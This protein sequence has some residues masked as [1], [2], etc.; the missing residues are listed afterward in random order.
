LLTGIWWSAS[1]KSTTVGYLTKIK[2]LRYEVFGQTI[3][4]EAI[5]SFVRSFDGGSVE[6]G[7]EIVRFPQPIYTDKIELAGTVYTVYVRQILFTT[8]A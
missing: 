5:S 6:V 3:E 1:Y 8:Y 7:H 4:S 2:Y